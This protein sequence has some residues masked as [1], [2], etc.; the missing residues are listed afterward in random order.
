MYLPRPGAEEGRSQLGHNRPSVA[1]SRWL[2]G[3][4][5]AAGAGSASTAEST[6]WSGRDDGRLAIRRCVYAVADGA[7][8]P[9]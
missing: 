9:V 6:G 5:Q 8:K 3:T 7:G 4:V 2:N 1:Y